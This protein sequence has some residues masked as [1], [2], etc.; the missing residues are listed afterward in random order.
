[1]TTN[2]G[3][4][5]PAE[6]ATNWDVPLNENF[7]RMDTD[8]EIRDLAQNRSEYEPKD[9]ALYR[10]TDTGTVYLGDGAAW[11]EHNPPVDGSGLTVVHGDSLA[12]IAAAVEASNAVYL[13]PKTYSGSATIRIDTTDRNVA[14]YAGGATIDYQGSG[15]AVEVAPT[16]GN[17]GGEVN[18]Y[19]G[20]IDG[21][22]MGTSGSVG[23]A[24]V[25]GFGNVLSPDRVR[26]FEHGIEI[27]NE[28]NWSEN[29]TVRDVLALDGCDVGIK[30]SGASET[31]GSGTNSFR[32]TVVENVFGS[33]GGTYGIEI[34]A[35]TKPY[36]SRISNIDMFVNVDDGALLG[37]NGGVDMNGTR[38]HG[39]TIEQA[40]G[41]GYVIDLA[42]I[43]R[44]PDEL[45]GL[46]VIGNG[47]VFRGEYNWDAWVYH[48][49]VNMGGNSLWNFGALWQNPEDLTVRGGE[50]GEIAFHDG[51]GTP[52]ESL[53]FW[54]GGAWY[55]V[56]DGTRF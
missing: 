19:G 5:T 50:T 53:C 41:V 31:G 29:N 37:L 30:L 20:H 44:G 33:V 13:E 21:P 27:Q 10:A 3:Y 12:D 51:S 4:N 17:Y 14:V 8:V 28:E 2:H 56:A 54:T 46:Q 9:G 35:D 48:G 22:G 49:N 32:H 23:I 26:G 24:V 55:N 38:I 42:D 6:G 18:W 11:N 1:M 7:R 36:N 40:G 45:S 34:G 47:S 16:P 15:Y 25:D 43:F 39:L 52:S